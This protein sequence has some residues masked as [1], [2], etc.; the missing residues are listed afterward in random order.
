[1]RAIVNRFADAK[2]HRARCYAAN[3]RVPCIWGQGT[4]GEE[5]EDK[6][7][8]G[9]APEGT[10]AHGV[11]NCAGRDGF[12]HEGARKRHSVDKRGKRG[13][14]C[15]FRA[16]TSEKSKMVFE[17][18]TRLSTQQMMGNFEEEKEVATSALVE[19]SIQSP[20]Q[21]WINICRSSP[22]PCWNLKK[23]KRA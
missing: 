18:G 19:I 20:A 15:F 17:A 21:P 10:T 2:S 16:V 9:C 6:S 4:L 7:S 13:T 23:R 11:A 14:Q 3:L 22:S 8:L 5:A 1:M 12:L